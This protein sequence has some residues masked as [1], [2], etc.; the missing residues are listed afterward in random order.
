ML[1]RR[2]SSQA[3]DD[4]QLLDTLLMDVELDNAPDQRSNLFQDAAGKLLTSFIYK[5]STQ[6]DQP[7]PAFKF[8]WHSFA[9]PRV[10]LF[11]WLLTKNR[12]NCK[13]CLV[14]K[15]L[16]QHATC[17][18]CGAADES[19]DHIFSGCS[20]VTTFWHAIGWAPEGIA[21]VTQLWE[22]LTPPR[23]HLDV[24]HPI[25]ILCCWEIW[26]HRN[27]VVFRGLEQSVGRLVAAC[28]ESAR[29]WV[30][31]IPRKNASL[32]AKWRNTFDM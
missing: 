21:P 23:I 22:T 20:F 8:V 17:E 25:I 14:H 9:P 5:A 4:L 3:A 6:G 10:K 13:T 30:C 16:L 28:K 24:A 12:I 32:A 7:S 15:N 29:S 2:L 19:A 1:Q 18:I 26:K 31:R 27:E 11:A